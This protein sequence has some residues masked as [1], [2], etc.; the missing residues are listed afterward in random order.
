MVCRSLFLVPLLNEADHR[1]SCYLP[2]P[3]IPP[4]KKVDMFMK[5]MPVVIGVTLAVMVAISSVIVDWGAVALTEDMLLNM[6]PIM[7]R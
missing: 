3:I 4:L 6:V 2:P 7:P 5:G 1:V